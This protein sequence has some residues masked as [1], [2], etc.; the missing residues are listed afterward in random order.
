MKDG[1]SQKLKTYRILSLASILFGVIL[2]IYMIR[3]EDEPGALPLFLILIGLISFIAI[4]VRRNKQI[5]QKTAKS[6][7]Q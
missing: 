6:P 1:I 4:R 3:V 7:S 5:K 2:L